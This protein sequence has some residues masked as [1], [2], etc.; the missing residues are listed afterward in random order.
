MK[1]IITTSGAFRTGTEIADAVTAYALALARV[2]ALDV[3]DIPFLTRDGSLHRAQF[4]IGWQV[5]TAVT[6]DERPAD[7]L[8]EVDTILD[9][10]AKSR[11]TTLSRDAGVSGG[12]I[13][14]AHDTNW[15]EF[16]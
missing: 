12:L 16:I 6:S 4:R 11:S 3:V 13:A 9:L 15:D 10:L 14:A 1:T 2:R 7:E 8:M 5:E